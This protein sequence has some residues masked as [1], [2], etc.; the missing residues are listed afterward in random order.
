[1]RRRV[2]LL[3][4]FVAVVLTLTACNGAPGMTKEQ[5]AA[6]VSRLCLVAADQLREIH[7]DYTVGD[8]RHYASTIVHIDENFARRLAALTPPSSLA[9]A[10]A[11]Y[12]KA[13]ARVAQDDAEAVAAAKAGD[14]TRFLLAI[15][16]VSMDSPATYP[17]AKA[18]GARGCYIRLFTR[19]RSSRAR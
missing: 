12:R 15:R 6:K 2:L 1:M 13:T 11:N 10:A 16:K 4:S 14:V 19:R 18:M 7:L 8:W 5:Y 3:L 17:P 9:S